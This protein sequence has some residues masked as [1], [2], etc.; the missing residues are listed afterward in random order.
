MIAAGLAIML[1]A[2]G[3]LTRAAFRVSRQYADGAREISAYLRSRKARVSVLG[4]GGCRRRAPR[5][6]QRRACHR[7]VP[8]R[9]CGRCRG[10]SP[11]RGAGPI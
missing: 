8:H 2:I 3:V 6:S 4:D 7:I 1:L 10:A 11:L 9:W 5:Y